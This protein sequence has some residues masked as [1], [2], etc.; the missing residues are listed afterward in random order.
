MFA[1]QFLP[2]LTVTYHFAVFAKVIITLRKSEEIS[3][4]SVSHVRK[5][6]FRFWHHLVETKI[7]M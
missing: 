5:N 7:F 3:K 1:L 2:F 4:N 6:Q